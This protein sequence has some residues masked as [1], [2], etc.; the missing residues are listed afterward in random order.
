MKK[1]IQS[2]LNYTGGKYKLLSQI[3]PLFPKDIDIFVDLF[4]GGFNVGANIEAKTIV[5]NEYDTNVFNIIKGIY[6][7]KDNIIEDIDYYINYFSLSKTNK[8]GY[9]AL[10]NEW[11]KSFKKDWIRLYTLI[12]Y[13]F[14][15]LITVL[16]LILRESLI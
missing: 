1:V 13:S 5:Y 14:N 7:S 6:D 11:N 2:P 16:D 12:C 3:V 10:R 4:G 15:I 8:E 9:L